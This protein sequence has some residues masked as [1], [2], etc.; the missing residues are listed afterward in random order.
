MRV[1]GGFLA[2]LLG[3]FAAGVF[4]FFVM[5]ALAAGVLLVWLIGCVSGLFLIIALVESAWW[6]YAHSH[7][8]AVT[9]LGYYGY[10]AGTFALIPVLFYLKDKLAAWPEQRRE[11]I[12]TRR[13]AGLRLAHGEPF[14]P[15]LAQPPRL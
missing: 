8:A 5:L 13:I 4:G 3:V 10:A 9:A 15:T 14:E 1:L 11:R 6:L 12:A 2:E 7:H